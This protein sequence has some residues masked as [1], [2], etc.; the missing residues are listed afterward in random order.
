MLEFDAARMQLVLFAARQRPLREDEAFASN[1]SRWQSSL[2]GCVQALDE[3][4]AA[5]DREST[6]HAERETQLSDTRLALAQALAELSGTQ[7]EQTRVRHLSLHDSLTGLPNRRF[8]RER[9]EATLARATSGLSGTP[10]LAAMYIDLDGFKPINDRHGHATGDEL[11]RIVAARL[12]GAARSKDMV[13]RLGG[14]EFACVLADLPNR[15]RLCQL[16]EILIHSVSAPLQLGGLTLVVRPSIGIATWPADGCTGEVLLAR[17]DE[18]MYYAKR[19]QSG[20]AFFDQ[21]DGAR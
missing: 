15:Q 11:L 18:A 6:R 3:L 8:F 16:A 13:S 1:D 17:A 5:M 9:L 19:R 2:L 4:H 20:Y 12:T 7:A 14:D 10:M 21:C